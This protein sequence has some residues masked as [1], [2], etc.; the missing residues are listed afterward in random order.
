MSDPFS[1]APQPE[2]YWHLWTGDDGIS[3]QQQCTI[4]DFQLGQLG[5]GDSPQF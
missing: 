4:S 2:T 1:L 3:R 5:P